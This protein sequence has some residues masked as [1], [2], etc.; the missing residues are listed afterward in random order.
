MESDGSQNSVIGFFDKI[1]PLAPPNFVPYAKGTNLDEDSDDT[2]HAH[3]SSLTAQKS[4][5]SSLQ[6][7]LNS[8][9]NKKLPPSISQQWKD[10]TPNSTNKY[11]NKIHESP[12]LLPSKPSPLPSPPPRPSKN[13][14]SRQLGRRVLAFEYVNLMAKFDKKHNINQIDFDDMS[15]DNAE[16]AAHWGK[17]KTISAQTPDNQKFMKDA[18]AFQKSMN[19]P[20]SVPS[21]DESQYSISPQP[22]EHEIVLL[23]SSDDDDSSSG[24]NV[25]I[26][27][28]SIVC[29]IEQSSSESEDD[30]FVTSNHRINKT[31]Q[32]PSFYK[33]I[34]SG[35]LNTKPHIAHMKNQTW[36]TDDLKKEISD[37]SPK[38]SDYIQCENEDEVQIKPSS[39]TS[40]FMKKISKHP[41]VL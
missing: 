11:G 12:M 7:D 13:D 25:A 34:M 29:N 40:S 9:D 19:E 2:E 35:V 4:I 37:L 24:S 5:L 1:D 36:I 18:R 15:Y 3:S 14:L 8:P 30:V 39:Y 32:Y 33:T 41:S 23:P 26:V 6:D 17:L 21:G 16:E 20:K 27:T 31:C 28:Q 38:Q 10:H 22:E